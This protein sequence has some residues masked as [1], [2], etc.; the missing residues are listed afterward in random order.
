M[1]SLGADMTEG[2]LLEWLV[3]P[4]D[5]VHRGDIVAVV[6]T[7]KS[8][9]DIEVF[10]DGVVE[11]LLIEPGTTIDVGTPM[12]I[13]AAV[14]VT[15][16]VGLVPGPLTRAAGT[17]AA[18]VPLLG[19]AATTLGP[20]L[21]PVAAATTSLATAIANFAAARSAYLSTRIRGS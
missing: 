7:S 9:I 12:A 19:P 21:T 16:G 6:D 2:T 18:A 1:P 4:G 15:L 17:A 8:A 13:L 11:Q 3:Q 20:T 10:E 5:T 14:V